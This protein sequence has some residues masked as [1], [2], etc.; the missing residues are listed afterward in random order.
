MHSILRSKSA[1]LFFILG[2][3]FIANAIIAL[4]IGVKIFSFEDTVGMQRMDIPLFGESYSF[5]LSASILVWPFIFIFTDIINEY[6]GPR[7]VKFL[8]YLTIFLIGYSFMII[9]SAVLLAP[10]ELF[11]MGNGIF[12]ANGAYRGIFGQSAWVMI[13]TLFA[14]Y[15]SQ[16]L[17]VRI[18]HRIK[19]KT[20]KKKLWLRATGS[21]LVSQLVDTFVMLFIAFYLGKLVQG[22]QGQAWTMKQLLVV[23]TGNYIFRFL[24]AIILT[25]L[26]YMLDGLFEMYF[27]LDDATTM[28]EVAMKRENS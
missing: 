6:Y 22:D 3:F 1:R 28:K 23:G 26:I 5:Q 27:G 18:F 20:G 16:L 4:F 9:N 2:G 13:G 21:T 15:I 25:P 14:F 24:I 8:T 11:S 10:S 7:G 19:K 12:D 17:D